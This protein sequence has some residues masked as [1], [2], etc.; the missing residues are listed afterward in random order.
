MT[1]WRTQYNFRENGFVDFDLNAIKEVVAID[2]DEG[3][4]NLL[5]SV[6][7]VSELNIFAFENSRRAVDE[8]ENKLFKNRE[9]PSRILVLS[10]MN[11]TSGHRGNEYQFFS[12]YPVSL[13]ELCNQT[14][15]PFAFMTGSY[16]DFDQEVIRSNEINAE[17]PVIPKM[18]M[19]P[20]IRSLP[21]HKS[22]STTKIRKIA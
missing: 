12:R 3:I 2:D 4:R 11:L 13:Y 16:S 19:M 15:F 14:N 9:D 6:N 8:L 18:S 10:D 21:N 1:N 7:R 22:R 20:L 17:V 5:G